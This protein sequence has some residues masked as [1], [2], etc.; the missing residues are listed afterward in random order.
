MIE[1][2]ISTEDFFKQLKGLIAKGNKILK[3]EISKPQILEVQINDWKK[4]VIQFLKTNII[5]VPEKLISY[6]DSDFS[7]KFSILQFY[8][9][10]LEN[11]PSN[12]LTHLN[13]YLERR[14]KEVKKTYDYLSV[15]NIITNNES[16][17]LSTINE[18]IFFTLEKLYMLDNDHFYSISLIFDLNN[19]DY[20]EDET[21]EIAENLKKRGYGNKNSE[22]ETND[23]LKIT[24][25]GAAYVERKQK[26]SQAKTKTN[27]KRVLND[28][29]DYVIDE[30]KK[31]D[32]IRFGQ[33]IIFSEIEELRTDSKNLSKKSWGQLVKGKVLDLALKELISKK[34]AQFIYE[35][36]ID[37]KFSL[38]P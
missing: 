33:Q 29:I 27:E 4:I 34:T 8:I 6:I 35:S 28:K 32:E 31:L 13:E 11:N 17:K 26:S 2:K 20:R 12:H 15:S 1:L 23:F 7:D 3:D 21:N 22:W 30:L 37:D 24:V 10:D 14:I 25:K 5:G 16:P 18:K 36:L 38:L 19:I 9:N